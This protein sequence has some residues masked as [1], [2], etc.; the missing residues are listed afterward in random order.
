[1]FRAFSASAKACAQQQCRVVLR[2]VRRGP[3]AGPEARCHPS[4]TL[5]PLPH[6]RPLL[7]HR[8]ARRATLPAPPPAVDCHSIGGGGAVC[9]GG[10]CHTREGQQQQAARAA[11]CAGGTGGMQ[12]RPAADIF[13]PCTQATLMAHSGAPCC[14]EGRP[15]PLMQGW[16]LAWTGMTRPGQLRL[17]SG[18]CRPWRPP[19]GW[20]APS[21]GPVPRLQRGRQGG[22]VRVEAASGR[23]RRPGPTRR[24]GLTR[25]DAGQA[26]TTMWSQPAC[27]GGVPRMQWRIKDQCITAAGFAGVAPVPDAKSR[28]AS[29]TRLSTMAQLVPN[30]A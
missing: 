7:R 25:R 26:A 16:R 4:H 28:T 10:S 17:W 23:T 5:T 2:G 8:S 6:A 9:E 1:M 13:P 21:W 29:R 18:S 20:W 27:R 14:W 15:S 19:G 12:S 24:P 30:S 3:G 22:G 11:C